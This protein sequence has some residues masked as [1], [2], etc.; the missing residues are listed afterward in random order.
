[1]DNNLEISFPNSFS[2]GLLD[3]E[4]MQLHRVNNVNIHYWIFKHI[5]GPYEWYYH[6][7]IM[8]IPDPI[9]CSRK[10]WNNNIFVGSQ[11]IECNGEFIAFFHFEIKEHKLNVASSL[12]LPEFEHVRRELRLD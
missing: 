3:V 2:I 10:N 7:S 8:I 9:P 6:N 1:M 11:E 5:E 4:K 12:T